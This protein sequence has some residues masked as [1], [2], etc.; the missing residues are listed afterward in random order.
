[1]EIEDQAAGA[2]DLDR[3]AVVV[4]AF[5]EAASIGA[6]IRELRQAS[7]EIQIIVVDDGSDDGTADELTGL[8]GVRV[9]THQRNRGYGAALKTGI[10]AA[11]R[12]FVAWYDADGQHKPADLL[13]VARPVIAE[14]KD[15]VIGVRGQG[16]ARERERV[17]GK[18]LLRWVAQSLTGERIPD[19]NSGMR[20]FR[21]DMISRYLH[22]LPDGFSASTTSTILA[23]KRGW[24]VGYA[25]IT[26]RRRIGRSKV[27]LIADGLTTLQLILRLVVL[28]EAFKVFTTLGGGLMLLGLAYGFAVAL[29]RGMG[30]PTLA[31][32]VVIAGL[33]TIFLGIVADQITELRKERFEDH[34]D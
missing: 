33:L 7:S 24:R 9:E 29:R 6:T 27:R 2:A 21:R 25:P 10:R 28:F 26:S 34:P 4:P 14:E 11:T 13:A 22:L 5:N 3:L 16:S 32:T 17:V 8:D 18:A 31:G 20:C 19:L 15:L 12:P 23:I 30:F 1:M